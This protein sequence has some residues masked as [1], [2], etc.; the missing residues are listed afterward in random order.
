[1]LW[2]S[3]KQLVIAPRSPVW[4]FSRHRS[5]SLGGCPSS[6]TMWLHWER[7]LEFPMFNYATSVRYP[8][9]LPSGQAKGS[10]NQGTENSTGS[11]RR[12]ATCHLS[13]EIGVLPMRA[14]VCKTPFFLGL[15]RCITAVSQSSSLVH[16][17]S[18]LENSTWWLE[19]WQIIFFMQKFE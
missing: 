19:F 15:S 9:C 4:P 12:V 11:F 3:T 16:S 8:L 18:C 17:F 7:S 1:M 5:T 2:A 10:P 6:T 14:R 13:A